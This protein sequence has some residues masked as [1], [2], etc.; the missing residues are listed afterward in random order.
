MKKRRTIRGLIV[1]LFDR[2]HAL[3]EAGWAVSAVVIYNL[4]QGSV[5]PGP[6]DALFLPL[7]LADDRRVWHFAAA[8]TA[9]SV[10]GAMIAW[11]IGYFAFDTIGLS[12]LGLVGFDAA[13]AERYRDTFAKHGWLLLFLSTVTPVSTKLVSIAAGAFGLS[14]VPFLLILGA[15][16]AIRYVVLALVVVYAGH[17]L[18]HWVRKTPEAGDAVS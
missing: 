14:F 17:K 15:G 5:L 6:A 2:L 12:V 7:G 13:D 9:G 3:A 8:A 18:Q 4:L 10:L 16:R 11:A 1:S